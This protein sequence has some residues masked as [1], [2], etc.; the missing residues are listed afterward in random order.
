[1]RRALSDRS[2]RLSDRRQARDLDTAL[3]PL[4]AR[5]LRDV[6]LG[7]ISRESR[8]FSTWSVVGRR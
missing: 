7:E 5:L 1:V 6:G 8:P 4:D 3:S 2:H